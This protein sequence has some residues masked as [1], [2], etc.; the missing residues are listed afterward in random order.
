MR[1]EGRKEACGKVCHTQLD[2]CFASW[3][4]MTMTC[5]AYELGERGFLKLFEKSNK[6]IDWSFFKLLA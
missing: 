3:M 2:D 6:N 1:K 5:F 4:M